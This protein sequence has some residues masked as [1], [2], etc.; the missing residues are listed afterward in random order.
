MNVGPDDPFEFGGCK[1]DVSEK[2]GEEFITMSLFNVS[3]S[4]HCEEQFTL[5]LIVY[6]LILN[7][8]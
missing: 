5:S 2:C 8:S 1:Q 3:S 4:Y 7:V 6:P